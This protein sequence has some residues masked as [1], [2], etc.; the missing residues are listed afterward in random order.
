MSW[1]AFFAAIA[2][3]IGGGS[4][5]FFGFAI[6]TPFFDDCASRGEMAVG[7]AMTL[8]GLALVGVG[9]GGLA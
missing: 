3:I 7:S 6:A 4:L 1:P 9:I 8:I 2:Q 5:A